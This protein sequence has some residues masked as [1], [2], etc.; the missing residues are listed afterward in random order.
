MIRI[1]PD[2]LVR[3]VGCTAERA[4]VFG[5]HI[6][7]ACAFYG[8]SANVARL[9]AFLAQIGHESASFRY[10]REIAD[11]SAYEGRRDLGNVETGDGTR[12][13]G[14]GLIQT[15]GRANAARLR[16]RLRARLGDRVPDFEADPVLLELPE[17]AAWSAADYW[18]MRGLNALADADD[19]LTITRKINGGTNGLADRQARWERARMALAAS[20]AG[21]APIAEKSPLPQPAPEHP[22]KENSMSPLLAGLAKTV[23]GLFTPLAAEKLQKELGRHTDDSAVAEQIT[24]GVIEAAKQATGLSDPI[25]A[26]AAVQTDPKALQ[27]VEASALGLL[28][29]LAPVLQQ[30]DAIEASHLAR[31]EASRDAA[32]RRAE[33]SSAPDQDAYLTRSIVHL[34]VGLM[35][36]GAVLVGVLAW[37]KV[38]VSGILGAL[39]LAAGAAVREF[40]GRYQHRYGS[41]DGSRA[42]D[43]MNAAAVDALSRPTQSTR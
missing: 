24:A 37:L 25:Q 10:V 16:D 21:P 13:R 34:M 4:A 40:S 35:G 23:V 29:Q 2:L 9:A 22:A 42:K 7:T 27:Q 33:S 28:A 11:G 38:D 39:T 15:T 14:R 12:Y 32:S 20:S 18:D 26:V 6:D 1:T 41:S 36:G 30:L 19:F 8:I 3:A 17:W 5:P 31:V 43:A